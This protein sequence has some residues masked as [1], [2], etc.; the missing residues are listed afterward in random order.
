MP[1]ESFERLNKER[2][3]REEPLFANPRNAASGTLKSQNSSVVAERKLDA[4]LYY[5]LG[6][7]LPCEG[8]YEN[9][10]TA[11]SWGLKISE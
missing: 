11:A 7:Q 3:A 4:Y 9:L 5:L 6:E 1:W 10:Q 8:H 2:E